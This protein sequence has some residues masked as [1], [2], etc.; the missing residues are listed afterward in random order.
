MLT[1]YAGNIIHRRNIVN[2]KRISSV[3]RNGQRMI[4]QGNIRY[5]GIFRCNRISC[6]F[7]CFSNRCN[8]YI[9]SFFKG[10]FASVQ[11]TYVNRIRISCTGYHI[12]NLLITSIDTSRS[13]GRTI[14]DCQASCT[15]SYIIADC[16]TVQAGKILSQLNFQCAVT[17]F[18]NADVIISQ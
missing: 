1:T 6:R 11:L 14:G 4:L 17:I 15:E 10:Y 7:I 5:I 18:Y 16:N 12:G 9:T 2:H 13:N 8:S 3:L